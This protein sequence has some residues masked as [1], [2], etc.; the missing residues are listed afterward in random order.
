MGS[1]LELIFCFSQS[2]HQNDEHS[3]KIMK[4]IV[5]NSFCLKM[6]QQLIHSQLCYTCICMY[7]HM[8]YHLIKCINLKK[9]I[10]FNLS[11]DYLIRS[12]VQTFKLQIH[13]IGRSRSLKMETCL[14]IN[15]SC[16][17]DLPWVLVKWTC[18]KLFCWTWSKQKNVNNPDRICDCLIYN[19]QNA[20]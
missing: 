3:K 12:V 8:L 17:N 11:E 4:Y 6:A 1:V 7:T 19:K 2:S 16:Q 15:F 20:V 13:N 5:L 9:G 14:A 10:W 18:M